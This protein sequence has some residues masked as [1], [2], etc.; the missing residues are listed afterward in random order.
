MSPQYSIPFELILWMTD[1]L[2][3]DDE[4]LSKTTRRATGRSLALTCRALRSV[5]TALV[6]KEVKECQ[7]DVLDHLLE[8]DHLAQY[9]HY[10]GIYL[11][12]VSSERYR[13]LLNRCSRLERLETGAFDPPL[14][15][16]LFS[17]FKP[18]DTLRHLVIKS[19]SGWPDL[20]EPL[21]T[22]CRIGTLETLDLELAI[23]S[24]FQITEANRTVDEALTDLTKLELKQLPLKQLKLRIGKGNPQITSSILKLFTHQIIT[25]PLLTSLEIDLRVDLS[26]EIW[27]RPFPNLT[28]L[29]LHLPYITLHNH[30][31]SIMAS[32][33]K[34]PLLRNL[35]L[36]IS[37]NSIE[38][39]S[40][41]TAPTRVLHRFLNALPPLLER[42][43][44][45]ITF[46][47]GAQKDPLL[48]FLHE[49]RSMELKEMIVAARFDS[50]DYRG[51]IWIKKRVEENGNVRWA[52]NVSFSYLCASRWV[53]SRAR[54]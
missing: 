48:S 34:L 26:E 45:A 18:P 6:W 20:A 41:A 42:A 52:V 32:F 54:F 50:D 36:G 40:N 43:T 35:Y 13:T 24:T 53:L 38:R 2:Q 5:G 21:T 9:I 8:N 37:D 1:F 7:E 12:K 47:G 23:A 39:S 15:N 27:Y 51:L 16:D 30:L 29:R 22:L 44:F 4:N 3:V 14:F 31:P 10:L 19:I 49:R 28:H 25:P 11:G 46:P 17:T 33:P